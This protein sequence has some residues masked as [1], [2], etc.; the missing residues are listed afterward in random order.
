MKKS[1]VVSIMSKDRPG[2]ISEVSNAIFKLGGDIADV[3]QTV[4]SGYFTMILATTFNKDVTKEDIFATISHIESETSLEVSVKE[5]KEELV[6]TKTELDEAYVITVQ[7]QNKTGIVSHVA[8]LC[9]THEA[10][11]L[12]LDTVLRND[13]YSMVIQ[14]DMKNS[15]S[16]LDAL[17]NDLTV[18]AQQSDLKVTIQHNDI[19]RVTSEVSLN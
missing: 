12:D 17:K 2:I 18:Y 10:N 7:G 15:G 8:A 3:N 19:F 6:D 1:M 14:A 16:T 11:I 13:L 5:V 9:A 4:L